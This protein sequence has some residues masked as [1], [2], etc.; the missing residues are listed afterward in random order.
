MLLHEDVMENT[1]TY[2]WCPLCAEEKRLR[3]YGIPNWINPERQEN[4]G[5]H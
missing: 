3:K 1:V 2:V 5:K 4:C